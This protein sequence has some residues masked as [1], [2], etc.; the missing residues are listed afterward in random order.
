MQELQIHLLQQIQGVQALILAEWI[1]QQLK[2]LERQ[3]SQK[4]SQELTA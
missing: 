1:I 3:G 2:I 4:P